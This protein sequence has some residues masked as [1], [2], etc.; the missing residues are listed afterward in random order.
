MSLVEVGKLVEFRRHIC[1]PYDVIESASFLAV[2]LLCF[3]KNREV[4]VVGGCSLGEN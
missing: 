1:I 4:V 2:T 3:D